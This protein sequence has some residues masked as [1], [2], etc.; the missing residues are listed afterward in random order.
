MAHRAPSNEPWETRLDR[1]KAQFEER[2]E[3]INGLNVCF[4]W[5]TPAITYVPALEP[6]TAR[7]PSFRREHRPRRV[8]IFG[9]PASQGD[10]AFLV[11]DVSPGD[12]PSRDGV[13]KGTVFGE[14]VPGGVLCL[15]TERA[16]MW[17]ISVPQRPKWRTS[18]L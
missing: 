8:A 16:T 9:E 12:L 14:T 6:V 4:R 13:G 3:S 15:V 17:P 2:G 5:W 10:H 11:F 18:R 7:R 1:L